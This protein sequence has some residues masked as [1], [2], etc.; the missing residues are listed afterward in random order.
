[1]LNRYQMNEL[2]KKMERGIAKLKVM[3]VIASVAL[4]FI[5]AVTAF[6]T[7]SQWYDLHRVVFQYP[8]TFQTPIKVVERT[9]GVKNARVVTKVTP[10]PKKQSYKRVGDEIVLD[11]K[12]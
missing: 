12:K 9:T 11:L 7:V 8:V 1:M 5:G 4:G 10:G 2:D 3:I 6:I